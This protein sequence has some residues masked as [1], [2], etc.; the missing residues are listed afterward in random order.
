MGYKFFDR[1]RISCLVSGASISRLA[2]LFCFGLALF[3]SE[4]SSSPGAAGDLDPSFG[5]GGKVVT[6]FG[7]TSFGAFVFPYDGLVQSDGK[8]LVAG[9]FQDQS[10]RVIGML[11]YLSDGSLDSSFGAGGTA[12]TPFTPLAVILQPDGKILTAGT[13]TDSTGVS[14]FA[15]A[16]FNANGTL[17]HTFGSNGEAMTTFL[18]VSD[19][20]DV[21][22]LQPDGKIIAGGVTRQC[23]R[24][25]P[26]I[27][28]L[29][30]YNPDGSPDTTFGNAGKVID[31]SLGN[32]NGLGLRS[33]GSVLALSG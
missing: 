1:N 23:D 18:G 21:L 9:A 32:I 24:F 3:V 22:I 20:A 4:V 16:R 12:V 7:D 11:R 17:D 33:D 15:I 2:G 5:N 31:N 27:A 6:S 8:I 29:A 26:A 25:C 13:I 28:A 10:G 30:R 19:G 14:S